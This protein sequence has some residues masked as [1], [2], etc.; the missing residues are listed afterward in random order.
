MAWARNKKDRNQRRM[1][2]VAIVV[3]L[4]YMGM[5]YTIGRWTVHQFS[6]SLRG[7]GASARSGFAPAIF[8]LSST[9]TVGAGVLDAHL[10]INTLE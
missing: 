4:H 10:A 2:L 8:I 6:L 3:S 5:G 7:F 1:S 9:P